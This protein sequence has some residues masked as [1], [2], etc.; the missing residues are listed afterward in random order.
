MLKKEMI[1]K[2]NEQLNLEFY[3]ANLYLQ[4]SAWCGDK[5][6]EGASSFLKTHSQEEMQH[7]QRLFDYLD[8]TGSL[9][10][11]GA[12]AAP[13]IDFDS[14][15]DVFKLTYEHEQL[16]TAK[17]N[18]LAHAAMALQDYSTFNFLQWYVAEQ[19]EEEK[20]FRSILD[21]LALVKASE[22][23]LFFIDQDLKKMSAA[24]PSA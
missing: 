5:G 1:Q 9:P 8:D 20:L 10:V 11:L 19:H 7:M 21:K 18:E 14:L 17:I 22:G 15:A 23:G 2:L 3:S 6:F 4:M 16:I 12:I 24:A 13:P